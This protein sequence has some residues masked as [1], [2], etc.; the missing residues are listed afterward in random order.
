M[1][2]TA[3]LVCLVCTVIGLDIESPKIDCL[4]FVYV[5]ATSA[6]H[7]RLLFFIFLLQPFTVL[8]KKTSAVKQSIFLDVYGLWQPQKH[9][10]K[11]AL[12]A[13]TKQSNLIMRAVRAA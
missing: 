2:R 5:P 4:S 8:M 3:C 10:E 6:A 12:V 9:S 11:Q 1:A 7:N 13:G